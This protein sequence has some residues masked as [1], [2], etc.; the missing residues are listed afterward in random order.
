MANTQTMVFVPQAQAELQSLVRRFLNVQMDAL[1]L[2][3]L[4]T[5]LGKDGMRGWAELDWAAYGFTPAEL[6][7]ALNKLDNVQS[8][9]LTDLSAGLQP[10]YKIL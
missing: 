10:L 6:K 2:K 3:T 1:R 5:E 4:W 9:A 7:A 8:M